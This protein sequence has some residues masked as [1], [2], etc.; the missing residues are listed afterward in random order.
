M[1]LGVQDP[2]G[3]ARSFHQLALAE[4]EVQMNFSGSGLYRLGT[5]VPSFV[6]MKVQGW[7]IFFSWAI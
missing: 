7:M 3:L 6:W 5:G 4:Q 2:T 1:N